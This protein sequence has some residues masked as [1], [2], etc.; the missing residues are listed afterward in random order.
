[1]SPAIVIGAVVVAIIVYVSLRNS[2]VAVNQRVNSGWSSVEVQLKRRHDLVPNLVKAAGAAQRHERGVI[3][4][5]LSAR[6]KA[7]SALAGKNVAEVSSAE[8]ALTGG[9]RN[10]LSYA[11]DNPEITAT[12]NIATLQ[13][14][15]EDTEDQIAAARRFYNATVENYNITVESMPWNFVAA[16]MG[17]EPR[18]MIEFAPAERANMNVVPDIN[19]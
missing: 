4:A 9:L 11:E 5:I 8:V 13:R 2:L 18:S 12:T 1:M 15:I 17:L 14:Q 16:R 7:I 19:L 6:E 3:D 10:F